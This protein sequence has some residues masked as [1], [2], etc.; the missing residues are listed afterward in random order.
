MTISPHAKKTF[1]HGEFAE[2][3]ENMLERGS[4]EHKKSNILPGF[5]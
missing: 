5:L 3:V 4:F 2:V 1:K